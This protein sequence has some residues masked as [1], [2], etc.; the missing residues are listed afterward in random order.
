MIL[1][2]SLLGIRVP[3]RLSVEESF[4]D[5]RREGVWRIADCF[6]QSKTPIGRSDVAG[7]AGHRAWLLLEEYLSVNAKGRDSSVRDELTVR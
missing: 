2:Q 1:R 6:D 5:H 4:S 3:V 7:L